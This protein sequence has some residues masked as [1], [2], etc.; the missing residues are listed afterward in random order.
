MAAFLDLQI[1]Q[2]SDDISNITVFAPNDAAMEG[3]FGNYSGWPWGSEATSLLRRH[4]VP[5]EV[6]WS[7]LNGLGDDG[8]V[9]L[10]T[11]LDGF[12][13]KVTRSGN[14]LVLNGEIPV[15][16]PE[17]YSGDRIMIHGLSR[18]LEVDGREKVRGGEPAYTP[19]SDWMYEF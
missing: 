6:T 4:V 12:V 17:V 2:F 5:C 9:V 13:V 14:S 18:V 7:G 10:S 11:F 8:S 16:F 19:A 1:S 15:D 3:H